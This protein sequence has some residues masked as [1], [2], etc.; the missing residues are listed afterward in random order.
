MAEKRISELED[1]SIEISKM[2]KQRAKKKKI[3]KGMGY[4]SAAGQV[5]QTSYMHNGVTGRRGKSG[6]V[7]SSDERQDASTS[8]QTPDHRSRKS[9]VEVQAAVSK[10]HRQNG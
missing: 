2:E 9:S 1:M 4:L 7:H 6:S 10:Y 3:E 5:P 8:C